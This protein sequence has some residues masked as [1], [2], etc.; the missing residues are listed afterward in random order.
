MRTDRP[1][2][3]RRQ[4]GHGA[5]VVGGEPPGDAPAG[6]EGDRRSRRRGPAGA[7]YPATTRRS[8][9]SPAGWPALDQGPA[10]GD[11]REDMA[12]G[13]PA[14]DQGVRAGSPH[15]R[16]RRHG[17]LAMLA[18]TPAPKRAITS[19]E[20]PKDTNGSGTPVTGSSPT[21]APML[22]TAWPTS[23][24]VIPAATRPAKRSV[25]RQAIRMPTRARARNRPVSRQAADQPGLLA[26]DGE[27]EVGLGVGQVAPAGDAGADPVA[28]AGGRG[29]GRP[30]PG[31]TGSRCCWRR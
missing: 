23:Q 15:R 9:W 24:A 14:G 25:A 31:P 18:S 6:Q 20:P 2:D 11:G 12:A 13:A 21:T 8:G 4:A 26:D 22:I 30:G 16:P 17:R 1:G 10:D 29:S 19:D 5:D 28:R 7:P 3:G 27:D